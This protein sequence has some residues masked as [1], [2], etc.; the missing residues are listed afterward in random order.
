MN[1]D[2][3]LA[4]RATDFLARLARERH[5][6]GVWVV[7]GTEISTPVQEVAAHL[8]MRYIDLLSELLTQLTD[9]SDKPL[10]VFGPEDLLRWLR[11]QS[12]SASN[13]PILVDAIEPLLATFGK[14][15]VADFFRLAAR[16]DVRTPVLITTRLSDLFSVSDFPAGRT[17]WITNE[18]DY[19]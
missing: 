1:K 13:A 18:R 19:G 7:A 12:Y 15:G 5:R 17:F 4:Q 9:D 14:A 3:H 11:A 6:V 2:S 10:G 16:L 8:G